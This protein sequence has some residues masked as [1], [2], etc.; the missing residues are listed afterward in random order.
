MKV[1]TVLA[2][3]VLE[4]L[5]DK[6]GKSVG[7]NQEDQATS[8]LGHRE[9]HVFV[10]N[11]GEQELLVASTGEEG[12]VQVMELTDCPVFHVEG[13]VVS[14]TGLWVAIWGNGGVTAV[15]MPRRSG[16]GGRMAGGRESVFCRT[17]K[18]VQSGVEEVQSVV[19]HPGSVGESHLVVLTRDGRIRLYNVGEGDEVIMETV[20]GTGGKVATALGEAAVDLCFGGAGE[21]EGEWPL[22]VLYGNSQVF[23]VA[24]GLGVDWQVEG[25]LEVQPAREDNYSGEACSVVVCGGVLAMATVGG[26]IYH[27]VVLGGSTTSLHMYERVELELGAVSAAGDSSV[28]CCPVRLSTDGRASRYLATHRAGLHQVQL[29]MVSILREAEHSGTPPDLDQAASLVEHLICTRPTPSSDPAPVLGACVAYPPTTVL[30]LLS[31]N[32]LTS[33]PVA[34][35]AP[36]PPPLISRDSESPL[37]EVKSSPFDSQLLAILSRSST[38]PLLKSAAATTLSP[39]ETLE[40]L[41]GATATLRREYVAR[42]HVAKEELARRVATL[43]SRRDGQEKQLDQLEKDRGKVRDKAELLSERYEDVRDKGQ[44]LGAR[45]ETVLT[46]LQA[47][48]PHLSDKELAMAREVASLDR[49]VQSLEGGINQLREKEKYQRYQVEVGGR[50]GARDGK[51]TRLD[52]IKEVLQRDS[53]SIA[54]LVK[55]V[56]DVKKE[57]GM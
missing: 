23:C 28:F 16:V 51:D 43:A 35:S 25:P 14:R 32:S 4:Q 36:S 22:F 13:L 24:G 48:I 12:E 3:T 46:R 55:V 56:N 1:D 40:L 49:R 26:V 31:N 50:A 53:K 41:T 27:S 6:L 37:K 57:L 52:N 5:A 17:V 2:S 39:A 44:E 9:D 34:P 15:E 7:S 45:V 33:L 8:L 30:S 21:E 42:L 10:W 20:V 19:W 18:V 54:D 38:Q 47:K 29:P 11:R